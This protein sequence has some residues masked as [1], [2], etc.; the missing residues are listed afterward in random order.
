MSIHTEDFGL[1]NA[2]AA[3]TAAPAPRLIAATRASRSEEAQERALR[4][5]LLEEYCETFGGSKEKYGVDFGDINAF[6]IEVYNKN[7]L[8]LSLCQSLFSRISL[9]IG[10]L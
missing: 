8:D 5:K 2:A 3:T 7:V 10:R 1:G 4:P 9:I 6:V